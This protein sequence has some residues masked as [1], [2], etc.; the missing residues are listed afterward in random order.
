MRKINFIIV[1]S[2]PLVRSHSH[3]STACFRFQSSRNMV[4]QKDMNIAKNIVQLLS[5]KSVSWAIRQES[6][7]FQKVQ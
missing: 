2:L 1:L 6:L 5:K 7:S 4:A 3:C